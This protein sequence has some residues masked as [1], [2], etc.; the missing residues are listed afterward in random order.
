[1]VAIAGL[2]ATLILTA[3]DSVATAEQEGKNIAASQG[4]AAPAEKPGAEKEI[5][6]LIDAYNEAVAQK[7]I[8]RA[9]AAF[10]PGSDTMVL[11]TGK[12][13]SWR[14]PEEIREAH[15]HFF[16]SFEKET[17]APVWRHITVAGNVAWAASLCHLADEN[18]GKKNEFFMN[19]SAVF[20]Q[21][22]GKWHIV[23]LHI[24]N[25]T[26]PEKQD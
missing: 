6:A 3:Y 22:G 7:N 24:S 8:D 17:A 25:P 2:L 16:K 19:L 14:G 4:K 26:G 10:A 13:E 9:M 12:G 21:Q 23:L 1:M 20:Q 11:G 15:L 5:A 18:Q